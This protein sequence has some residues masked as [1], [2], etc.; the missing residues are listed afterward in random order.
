MLCNRF[1]VRGLATGVGVEVGNLTRVA[2]TGPETVNTVNGANIHNSPSNL[3]SKYKRVMDLMDRMRYGSVN[4]HR[5]FQGID[6]PWVPDTVP[7]SSK[8][9]TVRTFNT[10]L[11]RP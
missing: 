8:N 4:M 5:S 7:K 9:G 10:V 11:Q 1:R 2:K 6:R 3:P